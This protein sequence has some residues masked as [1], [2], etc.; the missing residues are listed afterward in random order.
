MV[1]VGGSPSSG[2]TSSPSGNKPTKIA[3][4]VAV[5]VVLIILG[6]IVWY[7]LLSRQAPRG[8]G[9]NIIPKAFRS[10]DVGEVTLEKQYDN[11]FERQSQYV[12]PF[13]EVKSPLQSLQR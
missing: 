13:Q 6:V 7:A 2:V 5:V 8:A 1:T 4:I 10:S 11:P 3:V 12:N 9:Q